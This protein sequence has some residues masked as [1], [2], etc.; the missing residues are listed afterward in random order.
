MCKRKTLFYD[1]S[2]IT[3]CKKTILAVRLSNAAIV[4]T[5]YRKVRMDEMNQTCVNA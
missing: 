3:K 2:F 5:A 4:N 1:A